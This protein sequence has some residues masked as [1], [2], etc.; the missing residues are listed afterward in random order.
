MQS[1]DTL[2][3]TGVIWTTMNSTDWSYRQPWFEDIRSDVGTWPQSE[4]ERQKWSRKS[5]ASLRHL[6]VHASCRAE[7]ERVL[8]NMVPPTERGLAQSKK[9]SCVPCFGPTHRLPFTF[10]R[11]PRY[12]FEVKRQYCILVVCS[13]SG[14]R[15]KH[16]LDQRGLPRGDKVIIASR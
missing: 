10:S 11:W 4:L 14:A 12:E 13:V 7:S 8:S 6:L 1:W 16:V 15:W 3:Q 9:M 5:G 2:I